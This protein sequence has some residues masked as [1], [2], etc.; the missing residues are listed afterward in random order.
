M[1]LI[2]SHE[3]IS[4]SEEISPV[5]KKDASIKKTKPIIRC[6]KPFFKRL[7]IAKIKKMIPN[8]KAATNTQSNIEENEPS[9]T[10]YGIVY[11]ATPIPKGAIVRKVATIP[12]MRCRMEERA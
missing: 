12:H 3:I 9:I 6:I 8:K 2:I 11:N 1:L 5:I 10:T 7:Q 4:D